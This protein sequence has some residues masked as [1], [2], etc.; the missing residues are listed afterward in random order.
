MA[1]HLTSHPSLSHIT[2]IGSR[3]VAHSVASSASRALTPLTL[4][5]G[6]KDPAIV[7]DDL[8]RSD[9]PRV[10]SVLMRGVFQAAGQNCIGIERIIATPNIYPSLLDML[11]PRVEALRVGSDLDSPSPVYLGA[12]I[13]GHRIP[14]LEELVEDAVS[15]G[16]T[17]HC[18]GRGHRHPQFPK[19]HYFEPTL[20]CEVTTDMRIAQEELFAPVMLGMRAPD[21]GHAIQIANGTSHALGC[22][23]FGKHGGADA[24]RVASEVRSGMVAVNDFAS[25]YM[26]NLPFGGAKGSGY[27]RFGGP[28]GLRSLCNLKSICRDG[29]GGLIK[30]SIPR[31]LDY[32]GGRAVDE[33]AE[34]AV[35]GASAGDAAKERDEPYAFVKSILEIGYGTWSQ[36]VGAARRLLK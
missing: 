29:Y 5:L 18:G 14:H 11:R 25:Y 31:A 23:V 26:C 1:P 21:T 32:P 12:L 17:L 13:S 30:T 6:G 28:E 22:S 24:E 10:C 9:L 3:A 35:D 4:E 16:A 19:G 34:L 36:S 33:R 27:G 20:L 15:A 7:L 2:F 8:P